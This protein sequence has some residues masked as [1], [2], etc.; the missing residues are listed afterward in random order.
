MLVTLVMLVETRFVHEWFIGGLL[1]A[2]IVLYLQLLKLYEL[3]QK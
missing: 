2:A 3:A 1:S